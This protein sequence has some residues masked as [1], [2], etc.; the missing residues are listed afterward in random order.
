MLIHD[1]PVKITD[2]LMMLGAGA[3]PLYL[4]QGSSQAAVFEGGLG[5]AGPL[6]R[7]QM[8]QLAIDPGSVKQV[9]IPHAHPD[10]VMAIPAFREMFA[11]V[12]VVASEPAARTLAAEKAIAMFLRLDQ[13]LTDALI[14]AGLIDSEHRPKVLAETQIAVDRTIGEGDA[15]QV[16]DVRFDVLATPGHSDCSLSFFEPDQ[17]ILLV[18]DATP[19]YLKEQDYWWP[20]YFTGYELYLDSM[21][22][23]AGLDAE[24]L[25]L[26][27]HAVFKGADDVR[28]YLTAAI[29]ATHEYHQHILQQTE[30]G[31]TVRQVAEQ[32][33][34]DIYEKTPW[35]P[36]DFFQK[37]CGLLVKQSLRHEGISIDK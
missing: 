10:H 15:I 7:Q 5:A 34:S 17:K 31:K 11:N 16:D 32:L 20:N 35:L 33:G 30:A 18:S 12:T 36:L 8:E 3:Y 25:C 13:A 22:R 2:N 27:H 4:V 37:N 19:Y 1:P 26:G 29:D 28:S 21:R 9:V 14:E 6:L 23:L 24:I